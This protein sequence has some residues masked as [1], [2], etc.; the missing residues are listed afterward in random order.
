MN[1]SSSHLSIAGKVFLLGEYAVL[2][3][4]PALVA[5]V[6]PRF[7]M[8]VS[9]VESWD[10]S[11]QDWPEQSPI[12]R[13]MRWAQ[14]QGF[15]PLRFEFIDPLFGAG[16]LGASTAQ[17]AMA[18]QA[19]TQGMQ[20]GDSFSSH[21]RRWSV[22]L[23]LY[24]ELMSDEPVPPSGAD[25]VAQWQGG[26]SFFDPSQAFVQDVW[27][28]LG[29]LPLMVFST[30]TQSKRKVPTHEHLRELAHRGILSPDSPLMQSLKNHLMQAMNAL[31]E[32]D[33]RA[34]AHAFTAYGNTLGQYDLETQATREDKKVLSHLPHVLGVKGAGALQSD[35]ILVLMEPGAP[36]HHHVIEAAQ[37]R[38]L[39]LIADGLTC[40]MGVTCQ[41]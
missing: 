41:A 3:G 36:H 27:A 35:V 28:L 12:A 39:K 10:Q 26:V 23:K 6:E 8:K 20:E 18:Y 32:R 13:L 16:G 34:F 40:Q 25:L 24:R 37:E 33:F 31:E 29:T 7:Q 14:A 9:S 30:T 22:L 15:A 17:F 38:G 4:L 2:T 1:V 11:L 19:I 5:T 21:P